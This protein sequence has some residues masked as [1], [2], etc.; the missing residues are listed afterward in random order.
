MSAVSCRLA[1]NPI[2]PCCRALEDSQPRSVAEAANETVSIQPG[3]CDLHA[4]HELCG[5]A[6]DGAIAG[7]LEN[8]IDQSQ[9]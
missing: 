7:L 6:V 8:W 3:E 2:S 4:V 9:R 5:E 1:T